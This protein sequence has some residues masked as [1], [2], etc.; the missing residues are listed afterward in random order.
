MMSSGIEGDIRRSL[1]DRSK[2]EKVF[3]P[4]W[5]LLEDYLLNILMVFGISFSSISCLY[6]EFRLMMIVM[7]AHKADSLNFAV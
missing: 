6:V 5:D 7:R 3:R 4:W 1:I 2:A